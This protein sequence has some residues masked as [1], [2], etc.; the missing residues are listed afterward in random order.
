[1]TSGKKLKIDF[2]KNGY[3]VCKKM[4]NNKQLLDFIG[5]YAYNIAR[6]GKGKEDDMIPGTPSFY[7]DPVMENL[8]FFM[9]PKIESITGINLFQTYAYMRVYKTGDVLHKHKD[10]PECEISSTI[11]LRTNGVWPIHINNTEYQKKNNTGN[12]HTASVEL[13]PGDGMI[14][15]GGECEHWREAYTE[16][17]K[18]AQVFLH[19]VDSN[20]TRTNLKND[21]RKSI[22][23]LY[24]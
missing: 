6:E 21:G 23:S 13:H 17:S 7:G 2:R 18:N 15:I 4:I 14:Y 11:C 12:G 10:R 8:S 20:G 19:Y 9:K 1:M 16:G 22:F 5:I 3:V 24:S